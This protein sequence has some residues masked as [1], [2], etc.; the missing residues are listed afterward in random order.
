MIMAQDRSRFVQIWVQISALSFPYC[1]TLGKFLG[2]SFLIHKMRKRI[3]PT[4]WDWVSIHELVYVQIMVT[5]TCLINVSHLGR[6]DAISDLAKVNQFIVLCQS[7]PFSLPLVVQMVLF[8]WL[9]EGK[10]SPV[11]Y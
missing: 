8:T 1:V 3:V 6:Y 5:G 7:C 4:S 9:R 11:G 2:F 10:I